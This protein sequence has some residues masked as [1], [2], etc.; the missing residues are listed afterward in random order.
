MS[1]VFAIFLVASGAAAHDFTPGVLS[2]VERSAGRYEFR[3]TAPVDSGVP[4]EVGFA[5]PRHCDREGRWII[6]GAEGL[7]GEISFPRLEDHRARDVRRPFEIVCGA[8]RDP[9]EDHLLGG[10]PGEQHLQEVEQLLLRVQVAVLLGSVQGVAERAPSRHDRHLLHRLRIAYE[11]R[12]ERVTG[13]VIGEDALL[14]VRH[15]AAL[16]QAGDHTLEGDVEVRL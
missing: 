16:L 6:C 4:L 8:V 11:V 9:A 12:H 13:F 5:L 3:W 15:D 2:I 7:H 14:L 1:A 10:P